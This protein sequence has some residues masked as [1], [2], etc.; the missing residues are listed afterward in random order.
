MWF[1]KSLFSVIFFQ[2]MPWTGPENKLKHHLV[3][4]QPMQESFQKPWTPNTFVKVTF[5]CWFNHTLLTHQIHVWLL[6]TTRRH[7]LIEK[8]LQV[9]QKMTKKGWKILHSDA[10]RDIFPQQTIM[11]MDWETGCHCHF[12]FKDR[13]HVYTVKNQWFCELMLTLDQDTKPEALHSSEVA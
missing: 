6:I 12:H 9:R 10:T 3:L 5:C 4:L 13:A 1:T 2:M 7:L 8:M 11:K